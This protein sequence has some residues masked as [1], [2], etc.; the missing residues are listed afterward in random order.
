MRHL[1]RSFLAWLD[2]RFP[3]RVVITQAEFL[4]MKA[5]IDVMI[6]I[7]NEDR[8]KKIEAEINKFNLHMGF[9]GA[10]LPKSVVQPFQR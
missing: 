7:L 1:L 10:V 8:L 2:K 3:E 4:T 5:Q 9:G 6:K